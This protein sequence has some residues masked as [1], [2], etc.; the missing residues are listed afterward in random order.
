MPRQV[1]PNHNNYFL[2][3]VC[4]PSQLGSHHSD[5]EHMLV[6][7]SPIPL[8][9]LNSFLIRLK[10]AELQNLIFCHVDSI[11]SAGWIEEVPSRLLKT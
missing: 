5:C 7:L 10:I 3:D 2:I 1:V 9:Y 6:S 4:Q 11:V 8:M